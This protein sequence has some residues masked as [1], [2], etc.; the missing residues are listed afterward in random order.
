[1]P[2][3]TTT[4]AAVRE[5]RE[6][7]AGLD[8]IRGLAVLL[9]VA[10]HAGLPIRYGGV[11]GV[12]IFF[13]LSGYLITAILNLEHERDGRISLRR[14]Y[15]RRALRLVPALLLAV[16]VTSLVVVVTRDPQLRGNYWL[17]VV[18][19]LTYTMDFFAARSG[20]SL[21]VWS[22]TWSLAVEEQFYLVWPALLIGTLALT[23]SRRQ[24]A[25][26]VAVAA[27]LAV[28]WRIVAS[29]TLPSYR[30]YNAPDTVAY[31]LLLGCALALMP[32]MAAK[33]PAWLGYGSAVL[34]A[35]VASFP[36][37]NRNGMDV[38]IGLYAGLTAGLLAVPVIAAAPR[39][40]LLAWRPLVFLGTISYGLYLWHWPLLQVHPF[41]H[42]THQVAVKVLLVI[43]ATGVAYLSFRLVE[44][45]ILAYKRRRFENVNFQ[46]PEEGPPP[47]LRHAADDG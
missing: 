23:R 41:G 8:G 22:H 1:M 19:A 13:V 38:T 45:P 36:S 32:R 3:A 33:V 24:A 44:Q 10:Y 9:V 35:G 25:R 20:A 11:V 47:H 39:M 46:Q 17:Q 4:I 29:L 40:R 34:A 31:A 15:V 12:T 37:I 28:G 16:T 30:V 14:F 42:G 18:A 7:V 27:V 21:P 6:R 5:S 2:S 43:A 26:V